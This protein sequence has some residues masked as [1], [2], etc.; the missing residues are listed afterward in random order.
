MHH[1]IAGDENI[2]ANFDVAAE[3]RA[4]GENDI[5]AQSAVMTDVRSRHEK[6][7]IA[8]GRRRSGSSAAMDLHML[9]DEVVVADA[10]ISLLAF[11]GSVLG[12]IAEHR[13]RMNFIVFADLG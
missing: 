2:V 4:V 8:D 6:I 12:R 7:V 3:Q 9:A 1:A 10:Q 5:I 11:V 13:A